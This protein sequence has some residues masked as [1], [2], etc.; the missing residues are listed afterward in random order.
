MKVM[1][2]WRRLRKMTEA[3]YK[4]AVS[5]LEG[6]AE[7]I[8]KQMKKGQIPSMKIPVRTKTNIKFSRK[9]HVWTLAKSLNNSCLN[10]L[11]ISFEAFV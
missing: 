5:E 10:S 2:K 11:F 1:R 3:R 7:D 6:I 8:Y 4:N 9:S